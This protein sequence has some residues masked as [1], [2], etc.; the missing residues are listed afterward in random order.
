MKIF[1]LYVLYKE[2]EP[3]GNP[4]L[5]STDIEKLRKVMLN[6]TG[7]HTC[8]LGSMDVTNERNMNSYTE[9]GKLPSAKI[10]EVPTLT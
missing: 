8:Y 6:V 10:C 2:L 5:Y 7:Q 4:V 9:P 3:Y 1:A